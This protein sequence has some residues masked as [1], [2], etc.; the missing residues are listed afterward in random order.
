MATTTPTLICPHGHGAG[1]PEAHFC[2]A[3]GTP[4]VPQAL[5]V[6][7]TLDPEQPHVLQSAP[8]QP[9]PKAP[10]VCATCGG[11]GAHL[12]ADQDVCT[13][14]GWLRPLLP[15]YHLD[16]S[17]FLWAQDGQAMSHL[18]SFSALTSAA[19][20][21]SDHVGRPWIEATFNGIRVGPKQLPDVWAQAVL[22]GR[23]LGLSTMPDVY[24]AG[25]SMWQTYTFGSET[26]SFIVLGTSLLNNFHDDDLLFVLAREMG[27]C[28][29]G[30]ALWKTV[31]RFVAGNYGPKSSLTS[32][33]LMGALNPLKLVWSA[34]EMPLMMWSRQSEITADRAG[35]MAVGDEAIA[36]RVLL[37]WSIRSSTFLK[38]VNIDEWMKQEVDS[39]AAMTRVSEFTTSTTMYTTRRLRLLG[40][41]ARETE[42]MRWSASIQPVRKRILP[43]PPP[44]P[45]RPAKPD[46]AANFL[47]I[48]CARCQTPMRIPHS[49]LAG[50][51]SLNVRCPN[52]QTV[53]T[54]RPKSVAPSPAPGAQEK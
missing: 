51:S 14:C 28:R 54:L 39:D 45:A 13:E 27:H 12:A 30:H 16:R 33:G 26:S 47:R 53:V 36:R 18:D 48:V 50:K 35:L 43:P 29:A 17:V 20:A 2:H 34:V 42:L 38:R 6:P 21:V 10:A 32:G 22:A 24:V 40:Q 8:T 44:K 25:D 1:F 41:A 52:C 23:I 15:D 37:G 4:L 7:Q 46:A 11:K 5:E 49:V 19:R 31:L 9:A 3:C